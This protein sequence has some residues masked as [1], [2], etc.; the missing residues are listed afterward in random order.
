MVL[1]GTKQ[2]SWTSLALNILKTIILSSCASTWPTNNSN[3]SSTRWD[4]KRNLPTK[5][6]HLIDS[7]ICDC[8]STSSSG[9]QFLWRTI[10]NRTSDSNHC[11]LGVAD[12]S[13]SRQNC[14]LPALV[15]YKLLLHAKCRE[16]GLVY[17]KSRIFRVHVRI[18]RMRRLPYENKMHAKGTKQVRESAAVSDS[19]KISCARKVG[20]PRIRKLSAHEIFWIYSK[21]IRT[22]PNY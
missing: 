17:R 8:D 9:S 4:L 18:F 15:K 13:F 20:E 1:F 2:E 3:T 14:M 7:L 21:W 10:C 6:I 16:M 5:V 19:T 11:Q 12:S 22:N